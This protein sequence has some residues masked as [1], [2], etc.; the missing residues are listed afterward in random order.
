MKKNIMLRLSAILLVAVLLTTCVISGTW[1]K[2]TK[3]GNANDSARVAKWGVT[4]AAEDKNYDEYA[5]AEFTATETALTTVAS[6]KVLAPGSGLYF[7]NINLSG[8]PEVAVRVTYTANLEFSSGWNIDEE[9][10]M[11]LQF[12]VNGDLVEV[13]G[14]ETLEEAVEAAIAAYTYDYEADT[15]LSETAQRA[16]EL[17]VSCYWPFS[18]NDDNDTILGD[19]AAA[20]NAPTVT[21]TVTVTVTQLDE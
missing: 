8:K 2:Y 5:T 3:T 1:A 4:V 21:L 11:P 12:Y 19:L 6:T 18:V 10:Y 13:D 17:V 9:L 15:D 20:G 7:A 16:D 14:E